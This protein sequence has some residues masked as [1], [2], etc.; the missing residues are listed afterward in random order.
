MYAR[1]A[2]LVLFALCCV[3]GGRKN[4]GKHRAKA[5]RRFPK[6]ERWMLYSSE[7]DPV[8]EENGCFD[9]YGPRC[10]LYANNPGYCHYNEEFMKKFCKKSCKWCKDMGDRDPIMG[11]IQSLTNGGGLKNE[12]LIQGFLNGDCED[13]LDDCSKYI[14]TPDDCNNHSSLTRKYCARTCGHCCSDRI[15]ECSLF[16]KRESQCTSLNGFFRKY[17]PSTCKFC[18]P[19]RKPAKTKDC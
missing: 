11:R 7:Y 3:Q 18:G 4:K 8:V 5:Y 9:L 14:K 15:A 6:P 13:L 10:V 17:C 1:I 19:P 12:K 16:I 2:F